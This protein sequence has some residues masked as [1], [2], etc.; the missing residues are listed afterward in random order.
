MAKNAASIKRFFG[1][2]RK[3]VLES[4]VFDKVKNDFDGS[5]FASAVAVLFDR[6]TCGD[7]AADCLDSDKAIEVGEDLYEPNAIVNDG[8]LY[9]LSG[10]LKRKPLGFRLKVSGL[11]V[12]LKEGQVAFYSL[13]KVH[14]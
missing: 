6:L 8:F 1:I 13:G 10:K 4:I 7:I 9:I 3:T 11:E 14:A 12:E 2:D 5:R